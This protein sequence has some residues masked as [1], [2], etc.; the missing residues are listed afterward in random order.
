MRFTE[1]ELTKVQLLNILQKY[2]PDPVI[3]KEG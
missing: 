2:A 1:L 3:E